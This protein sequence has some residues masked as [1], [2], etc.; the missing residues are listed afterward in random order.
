MQLGLEISFNVLFVQGLEKRYFFLLLSLK[1]YISDSYNWL[2]TINA[3]AG[4]CDA[5]LMRPKYIF[6][7]IYSL[8]IFFTSFFLSTWGRSAEVRVCALAEFS[9][10]RN[11]TSLYV[12]SVC[13]LHASECGCFCTVAHEAVEKLDIAHPARGVPPL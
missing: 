1:I 12:S 6:S 4:F 9:G 5:I 8:F 11:V 10:N 13:V 7:Y 2:I 3:N